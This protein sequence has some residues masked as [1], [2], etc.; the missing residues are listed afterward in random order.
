MD[1]AVSK[2]TRSAKNDALHSVRLSKKMLTLMD[3]HRPTSSRLRS[4]SLPSTGLSI[5]VAQ[6][7]GKKK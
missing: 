4:K 6:I 5:D 3:H 1:S 2:T 7:G